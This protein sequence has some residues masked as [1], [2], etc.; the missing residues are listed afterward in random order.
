MDEVIKVLERHRFILG[1]ESTVQKQVAEALT[2][3]AINFD[4]EYRLDPHNRIDFMA[5]ITGIEVKLKGSRRAILRQ[6]TRYCD[7][8]VLGNLILL[9]SVAMGMPQAIN[10]RRI[11]IV[12]LGASWI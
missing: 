8:A 6:V 2:E 11:R 3:A 5:G 10:G 7:F 12:S 4:R 9:S 1:S